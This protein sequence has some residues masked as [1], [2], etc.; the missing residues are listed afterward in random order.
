[1]AN[2]TATLPLSP[3]ARLGAILVPLGAALCLL[4]QVSAPVALLGGMAIAATVGNPYLAQTRKLAHRFL[5]LAVVGLGADIDLAVVARVGAHGVAYTVAGI[6]TCFLLGTLLAR[7]LR[8][9]PATGLL[10]TVGTAICGGSAIAAVLPVVRPKDEEASVALAIVFLLNAV[11]LLL[12]PPLGRLVGLTPARFGV[13]AALA[14]H[15][16]SSVVGAA[17]SYGGGALPI[18]TTLKLARALWIVPVTLLVGAW[19]ARRGG[20]GATA[21]KK[22]WFIAGFLAA[23]ALVTL[24]PVLR[25]EGALVARAARQLLVVTLFLI[26]LG[27]TRAALRQ[28]GGRPF[29]HGLLLW[30]AMASLSLAGVVSGIL[31]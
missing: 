21:T 22:P 2:S 4:P 30:I 9:P 8:V 17:L 3:V 31:V 27:L 20:G 14:I 24:F 25:P 28:A 13:W 10:V 26:G 29:A 7:L 11:A 1:M 16:T 6:A 18:A 23:S 15:D 19:Q 12:F 5:A